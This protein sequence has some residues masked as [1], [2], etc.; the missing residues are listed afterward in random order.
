MPSRNTSHTKRNTYIIP[1]FNSRHN[2]FKN[3]ILPSSVTECNKLASD[4]HNESRFTTFKRRS[5]EFIRPTENSV[6]NCHNPK[7]IILVT[8]L[9]LGLSHLREYKFK[10]EFQDPSNLL[11]SRGLIDMESTIRYFLHRP[12][13]T[14]YCG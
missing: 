14:I 8:I 3:I 2:F 9:A 13:F 5:L 4:L 7:G 11:C 12:L 1:I 6:F 10:H